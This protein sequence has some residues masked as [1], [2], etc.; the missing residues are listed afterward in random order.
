MIPGFR[1]LPK[2]DVNSTTRFVLSGDAMES[3]LSEMT[4]DGEYR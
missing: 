2:G 4:I 3:L 1:L